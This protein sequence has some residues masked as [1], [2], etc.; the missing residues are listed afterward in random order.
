MKTLALL[1][2]IF[3][4]TTAISQDMAFEYQFSN[5]TQEHYVINQLQDSTF[6]Q[7]GIWLSALET[8]YSIHTMKMFLKKEDA[9]FLDEFQG[10]A[11]IELDNGEIIPINVFTLE[12]TNQKFGEYEKILG[13][14][15]NDTESEVLMN[16]GIKKI[17]FYATY[18]KFTARFANKYM[19]QNALA[20]LK[21]NIEIFNE[22][23]HQLMSGSYMNE[24]AT[25]FR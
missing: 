23:R 11:E 2:T 24:T 21:Y 10:V 19:M 13:F 22:V 7:W 14:H 18:G 16:K 6:L 9:L 5:H 25:L 17:I 1:I 3:I 20:T 12:D 15:F 4:S 8:E